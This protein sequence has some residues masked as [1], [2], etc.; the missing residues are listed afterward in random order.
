VNSSGYH[1]PRLLAPLL[2]L[3][4]V[5]LLLVALLRYGATELWTLYAIFLAVGL[6]GLVAVLLLR[7]LPPLSA[8]FLG[9]AAVGAVLLIQVTL[10]PTLFGRGYVLA[11]LGWLVLFVAT[12]LT[13]IDDRVSRWLMVSLI[14]IGAFEAVYGLV[15]SL[16]GV[17]YIG[18][19]FRG[20]G[21]IATGTLIARAHYAGLLNMLLPLYLAYLVVGSGARRRGRS[22]EEGARLW[23][24]VIAGS[25]V[26][27]AVLLSLS[28]G[29]ALALIATLLFVAVLSRRRSRGVR[30]SSAS[31]VVPMVLLVAILAL[32]GAIG[33]EALLERVDADQLGGR[34]TLYRTTLRMIADQP[35][36]GVGPGMFEWVFPAY[37]PADLVNKRFVHVH[38]DYMEIAV[39]WGVPLALIFWGFVAWRW[40]SSCRVFVRTRDPWRGTVA[41]ATAAGIFSILVHS[42][43]DFNLHIPS[44]LMVFALL[45]A[46]SGW[47]SRAEA[48][49][50]ARSKA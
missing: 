46:L 15:Q 34:P 8:G 29:G 39:E 32:G 38:N 2:T 9:L 7:P 10:Q 27:L 31:T 1:E 18:S 23:F 44:N 47:V 37:R 5:G 22:S 41:L 14:L 30:G 25:F 13:S 36:Q 26:G 20:R 11:A 6:A 19:Y 24:F 42:L 48:V 3:S 45:L 21:R 43:V 12:W 49:A 40:I 50:R 33:L 35:I 28:R 17:D 4:L 16:G